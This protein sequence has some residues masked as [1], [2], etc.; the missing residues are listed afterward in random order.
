MKGGDQRSIPGK[1]K[2]SVQDQLLQMPIYS[3]PPG[4]TVTPLLPCFKLLYMK[5]LQIEI[6]P[7]LP[8]AGFLV[9]KKIL[10]LREAR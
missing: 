6:L 1:Q 3:C 2:K 7:I 5:K 10:P 9:T 4:D 8:E